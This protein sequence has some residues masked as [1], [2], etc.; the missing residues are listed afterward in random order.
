M[1]RRFRKWPWRKRRHRERPPAFAAGVS[2]SPSLRRVR[3]GGPGSCGNG[4]R[5]AYAMNRPWK[6][7][8]IDDERLARTKLRAMLEH[9]P[10]IS[11][12]GEADCGE[13]ALRLI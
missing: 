3:A 11:I 5:A 8:I 12:N 10:Q 7:V 1:D 13:A 2:R 4:G 6:A 9:Y